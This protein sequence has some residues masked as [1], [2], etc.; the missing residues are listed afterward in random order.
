MA[1]TV[2]ILLHERKS[3]PFHIRRYA[4]MACA[5]HWRNQGY[6]V[7]LLRGTRRFVPAD[8]CFV[9]VD[10]SVVPDAYLEFAHRYPIVVNGNVRDIRKSAFSDNLL[11]PQSDHQGPVIVKTDANFAGWPERVASSNPVVLALA[12]LRKRLAPRSGQMLSSYDYQVLDNIDQVPSECWDDPAL[13]VERFQPQEAN[14][15]Y[16]NNCYMFAGD[17]DFCARFGATTP[18]VKAQ[19]VVSSEVVEPH[20]EVIRRRHQLG[21]GWGKFDYAMHN[22]RPVLYDINVTYGLAK[23]KS[24]RKRA[25]EYFIEHRALER[26]VERGG[27]GPGTGA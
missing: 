15:I 14:G 5:E 18:I 2:A 8:I 19:Y 24:R 17:V 6:R 1:L 25:I 21:F 20:P 7:V 26:L 23:K 16:Y 13:V 11:G 4:I 10:L 27:C 9:H 12:R 3:S 22:G